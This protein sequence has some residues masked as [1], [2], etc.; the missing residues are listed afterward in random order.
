MAAT[1]RDVDIAAE[2]SEPIDQFNTLTTHGDRLTR[3]P[4]GVIEDLYLGLHP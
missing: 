1:R 4:Q 3:N 2:I